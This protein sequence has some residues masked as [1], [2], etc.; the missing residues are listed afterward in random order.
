M[1]TAQIEPGTAG[2]LKRDIVGLLRDEGGLTTIE[3]ALLI[4]LL[5][6]DAILAYRHFGLATSDLATESTRQ[7]PGAGQSPADAA[8]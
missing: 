6:V 8:H 2:R 5:A 3:Y 7:L 1:D 4:A